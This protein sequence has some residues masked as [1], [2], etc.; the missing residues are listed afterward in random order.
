LSGE[1]ELSSIP[2]SRLEILEPVKERPAWEDIR[3]VIALEPG[4]S[5]WVKGVILDVLDDPKVSLLCGSCGSELKFAEDGPK[6]EKCGQPRSGSLALSTRLRLDD[7][8]GVMDVKLTHADA[9]SFTLLDGKE[10][11]NQML[12]NHISEIQLSKEQRLNLIGKEVEL[13]GTAESSPDH[14]KLE[15]IAKKVMLASTP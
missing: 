1:F 11:E 6:C 12:K 3:H 15:F 4:L 13:N 9:A 5:T 2:L 8:T 7:G 10:I 14:D